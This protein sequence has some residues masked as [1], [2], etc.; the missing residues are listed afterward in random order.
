MLYENRKGHYQAQY[1]ALWD[2][3]VP[4][5][6]QAETIQGELVRAIGRLGS[7]YSRNGNANWNRSFRML[8][9]YLLRHLSDPQVFDPDTVIQIRD[10]ID[11]IRL[12]S[13][14]GYSPLLYSTPPADGISSFELTGDSFDRVKDR[15]V[16]WCAAYP[17]MKSH[18]KNSKLER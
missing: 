3:L 14:P 8:T 6:G 12:C 17:E 18:T 4:L 11:A 9:N 2:A 10:D 1:D 7:E 15:V 16:E 13:R 5:S